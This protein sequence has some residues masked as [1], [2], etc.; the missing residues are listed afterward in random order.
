M[1][2]F[3]SKPVIA[4]LIV[5]DS[6][7][8]QAACQIEW[9]LWQHFSERWIQSD[10]RVLDSSLKK[11]H[12]TS[13]GQ[14]YA[15]FFALVANDKELFDSIWR[16]SLENLAGNNLEVQLPAWL[17]GQSKDGTWQVQDRN[18]ASDADLWFAY[19][20]LE[21]ARLWNKPEYET[22]AR[23]L[24]TQIKQRE[25]AEVPGLGTVLLPGEV[26]FVQS[27][28]LWRLNPS[29]MP[30]PLLRR[31][32]Q[33]DPLGPWQAIA[34]STARLIA[35]SGLR[36][37]ASDWVGYR[38]VSAS[39]G[40]F[41]NDPFKG[42]LG[43]YDA[44]RVYLWAGMT[45]IADPLAQPILDSLGGMASAT[46]SNGFPPEKVH[47]AL[48]VTEGRGPFGFSAALIPY[49]HALRQP[50]L[51]ELQHKHA[52]A[53]IKL[54]LEGAGGQFR[55][56]VYYDYMLSLFGLG[57]ADKRYQFEVDGRVKLFWESACSD[58]PH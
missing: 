35:H 22:E 18:S 29:Y 26:G 50:W 55:P 39:E 47:V 56:P 21:A 4:L 12:S 19:A 57:W 54:A 17:W 7:V 28:H 6:G 1:P 16:W 44:I 9:P 13:E 40:L 14:S 46:A 34:E 32:A 5:F 37:F 2:Q 48:G 23:L 20:L 42:D 27:D 31:L 52:F 30:I 15:L 51:V 25:V 11:N 8:S 33:F 41:V 36:G 3:L 10:G 45:P 24:L 53:G 38:A 58:T 43:S 49:F